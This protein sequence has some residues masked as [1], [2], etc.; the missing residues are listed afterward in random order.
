MNIFKN[1]NNHRGCTLWATRNQVIWGPVPSGES[2]RSIMTVLEPRL[3]RRS[4]LSHQTEEEG[5]NIP[6][7]TIL[8]IL[9]ISLCCFNNT[10]FWLTFLLIFPHFASLLEGELIITV[11]LGGVGA[12]GSIEHQ[13]CNGTEVATFVL[14]FKE[15]HG[16]NSA[17]II[18]LAQSAGDLSAALLM[19]VL[20]SGSNDGT[21][22]VG[23]CRRIFMQPYNLSWLLMFWMLGQMA[24]F[25]VSF[26]NGSLV[27]GRAQTDLLQVQSIPSCCHVKR[28]CPCFS[29][30]P[31]CHQGHSAIW[32]CEAPGWWERSQ[33][34]C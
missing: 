11:S 28:F 4:G 21:S 10:V 17:M 19:R 20:P 3:P 22:E 30:D 26:L 13:V 29:C 5:K 33:R 31:E 34:K 18:G 15:Y 12:S 8:P 23:F 1:N 9:M 32:R 2:L 27:K 25:F 7:D 14:F 6:R 24:C 16:W